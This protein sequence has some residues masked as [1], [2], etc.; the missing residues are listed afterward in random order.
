M[1][2]RIYVVFLTLLAMVAPVSAQVAGRL[3]GSVVDPEGQ[4]VPSATI[5]LMLPEGTAP[6]LATVTT[7]DGIFNLTAVRPDFYDLVVEAPGFQTYILRSIKV[8]PAL[9]TSLPAIS[10]LFGTATFRVVVTAPA[11]SEPTPNTVE[12]T[13]RAQNVQLANAEVT[14]TITNE[15]VRRLPVLDRQTLLLTRT[16]AGVNTSGDTTV[17]NGQRT[18]STNVTLDGINIQDNYIR[19][20]F[21]FTPNLI[22]LDQVAEFT[23]ITSN[24]NASMGGGASQVSLVTP[25]GTNDFHGSLYFYNR[26]NAL[27]ANTWF[28][29]KDGIEKPSFNQ[30]QVGGTI[31][32]PILQDKLFFTPTMRPSALELMSQPITR[33]SPKTLEAASSHT[34]IYKVPSTRSIFSKPRGCRRTRPW[35]NS[36]APYRLPRRSIIFGWATAANLCC[37]TQ[38]DSLFSERATTTGTT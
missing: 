14:T 35:S 18:S 15:Q 30:N 2:I 26:N 4:A 21:L 25:S 7:T 36:S 8:D 17:I 19:D 16:Q 12:V 23:L 11:G 6:M 22:T 10:L 32:G 27:A 38:Q 37:E 1:S 33:S 20:S 34:K 3:T 29:N 9:E 31:G 13:A 28:N 5:R 24:A